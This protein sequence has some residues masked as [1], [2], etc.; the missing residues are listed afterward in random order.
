MEVQV[1]FGKPLRRKPFTAA[2]ASRRP[3]ALEMPTTPPGRKGPALQTSRRP[4]VPL[5]GC[6][7]VLPA[8]GPQ[9]QQLH[10]VAFGLL[11]RGVAARQFHVCL[12][13]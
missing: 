6:A 1:P 4:L 2:Q 10:E 8:R 7:P 11:L 5:P 3:V 13:V 9:V 12:K